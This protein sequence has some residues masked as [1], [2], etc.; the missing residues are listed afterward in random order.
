MP[1]WPPVSSSPSVSFSASLSLPPCKSLFPLCL[2]L[3]KILCFYVPIGACFTPFGAQVVC[4]LLI[5]LLVFLCLSQ[6][7]STS[8]L[9]KFWINLDNSLLY[10]GRGAV[11]YVIRCFAASLVSTYGMPVAHPPPVITTKNCLQI[12]PQIS[13]GAQLPLVENHSGFSWV[14]SFSLH[15]ALFSM[16][17]CTSLSLYVSLSLSSFLPHTAS[18]S[19]LSHPQH[20]TCHQQFQGITELGTDTRPPAWLLV[21]AAVTASLFRGHLLQEELRQLQEHIPLQDGLNLSRFE[22]FK[23]PGR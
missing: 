19:L 4:L 7:L 15:V 17:R 9:V 18:V 12:L 2:C 16:C 22:E 21:A 8:A 5:F 13:W 20:L 10:R 1:L 23:P 6:G 3:A 14:L 11:L